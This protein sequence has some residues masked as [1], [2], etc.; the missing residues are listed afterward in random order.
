AGLPPALRP[1][2]EAGSGA[3]SRPTRPAAARGGVR[4][5]DRPRALAVWRPDRGPQPLAGAVRHRGRPP[6]GR[7]RRAHRCPGSAGA[8]GG[9]D[10]L[11]GRLAAGLTATLFAREGSSGRMRRM[12][13]Y[14]PLLGVLVFASSA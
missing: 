11:P 7:R 6:D 3:R 13:R 10:D 8:M 2:A 5:P 4:A 1:T 9:R 14:L 12:I